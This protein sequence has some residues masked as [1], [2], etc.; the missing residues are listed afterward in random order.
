MTAVS[1]HSGIVSCAATRPVPARSH[2]VW[3]RN[4]ALVL[5]VL[6]K[7]HDR[8]A[9]FAQVAFDLVAVREGGR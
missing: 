9:A 5:E 4:L 7:V 3:D 8:Q 2:A 1:G 6:S